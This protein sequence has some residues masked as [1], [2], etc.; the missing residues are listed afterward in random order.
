V[1]SKRDVLYH[2]RVIATMRNGY[3]PATTL[4]EEGQE[5][6][7]NCVLKR[8][9]SDRG[10]HVI[11]PSTDLSLRTWDYLKSHIY[12]DEIWMKQEYVRSLQEL[13]E[14]R[15]FIIGGRIISVVHTVKSKT[16]TTWN[17]CHV[18][19]FLTLDE[20]QYVSSY[21]ISFEHTT[22]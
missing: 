10:S 7:E 16:E 11:L 4:L 13:G 12:S 21:Y 14:W 1:A 17:Y 8:S 5:I 15:A 3:A 9:H 6:P 20:I 18:G 22:C 19:S 2:L